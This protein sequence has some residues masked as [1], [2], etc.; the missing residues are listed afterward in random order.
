MTNKSNP[1]NKLIERLVESTLKKIHKSSSVKPIN[2]AFKISGYDQ[3]A[4][5]KLQKDTLNAVNQ[6]NDIMAAA[7]SIANTTWII[8]GSYKNIGSDEVKMKFTYP[9]ISFNFENAPQIKGNPL[10]IIIEFPQ[11]KEAEVKR[12]FNEYK[13]HCKA[14]PLSVLKGIVVQNDKGLKITFEE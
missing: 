14:M 3:K 13:G 8:E 5:N 12:I 2:E 7:S 9:S 10:T 1:Q 4:F 6:L 11:D